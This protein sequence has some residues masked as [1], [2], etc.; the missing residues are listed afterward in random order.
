MTSL[1]LAFRLQELRIKAALLRYQSKPLPM[2]KP[3]PGHGTYSSYVHRGCRCGW[4]KDAK[5]QYWRV[6]RARRKTRES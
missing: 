1:D 4:C 2:P 6:F 3:E 5:A